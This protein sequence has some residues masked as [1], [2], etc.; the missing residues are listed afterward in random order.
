M[1]NNIFIF[2]V[3]K[4]QLIHYFDFYSGTKCYTIYFIFGD[5][6][7]RFIRYLPIESRTAV[8][9]SRCCSCRQ[10]WPFVCVGQVTP[11]S[12]VDRRW[13][14]SSVRMIRD[15]FR[16]CQDPEHWNVGLD[17]W[18]AKSS[19]VPCIWCWCLHVHTVSTIS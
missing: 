12:A 7:A 1:F 18:V 9:A 16:R 11:V 14:K 4:I 10:T 19:S 13:R 15:L 17:S 5:S 2:K 8:K 6:L 3:V